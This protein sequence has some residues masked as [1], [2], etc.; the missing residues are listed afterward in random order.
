MAK[1]KN[2]DTDY[3]FL[4]AYIHAKET[5]M[6]T[7]AKCERMLDAA[8]FTEAAKLIE[9]CGYEDMSQM[10]A[11]EIEAALARHRDEVFYDLA[12]LSPNKALVDIFRCKYDYH[13][14]K[15]LIKSEGANMSGSHLLS[16]SGRVAP[17]KLTEAYQ[18]ER[19]LSIPGERG[20][21][22]IEARGILAR[23]SNPQLADFELD[24]AYFKDLL[25]LAEESES[26][27]LAGYVKILIDSANLRSA[28]RTLRIDRDMDFLQ[29]VL[30]SGGSYGVQTILQNASTGEKLAA[31]Y[32]VTDVREAAQ[33]AADAASGG[34]LT[35]FEKVCDN[36]V[37]K[38]LSDS[39]MQSFG[40]APVIAYIAGIES[41]IAA[42]RMILT[43]RL[44]GISPDI[45]RERLRD[46]NA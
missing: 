44:S 29:Q 5:K 45:I 42:I 20:R 17:D 7:Y 15:V 40:E 38:Y 11:P 32:S 19:C 1:N 28:V 30:V 18:S 9:D 22:I 6:L 33:L 23:T 46:L 8:D 41:E 39:R 13:N 4:S 43:G 26:A 12:S 2:Q 14:A 27:F 3:L 16:G 37:A 21:A 24:R 35:E 31:L 34:P 25:S 10:S 36:T